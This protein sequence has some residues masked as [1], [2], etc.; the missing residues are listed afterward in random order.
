MAP[1]I[2]VLSIINQA[3]IKTLSTIIF[4]SFSIQFISAHFNDSACYVIIF[5]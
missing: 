4:I 5:G 1:A 3:H 2:L